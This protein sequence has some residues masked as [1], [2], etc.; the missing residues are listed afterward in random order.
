MVAIMLMT[1]TFRGTAVSRWRDPVWL[2]WLTAPLYW[3]HQFKE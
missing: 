2:G 3:V 1:D